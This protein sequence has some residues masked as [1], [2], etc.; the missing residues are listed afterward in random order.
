MGGQKR[1][2]LLLIIKTPSFN[3]V[4]HTQKEIKIF[5][6][7]YQRTNEWHLLNSYPG[8]QSD[9]FV[10]Y[11]LDLGAKFY[12]NCEVSCDESLLSLKY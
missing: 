3:K 5:V 6:E 4:P 11:N 10:G 2:E 1:C 8:G 12:G 7:A 9:K